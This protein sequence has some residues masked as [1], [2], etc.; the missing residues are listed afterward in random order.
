MRS[1]LAHWLD[2]LLSKGQAYI[3]SESYNVESMFWTEYSMKNIYNNMVIAKEKVQKEPKTGQLM[4]IKS[5]LL[6]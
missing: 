2:K 5:V 3:R 6:S 1:M 4:Y